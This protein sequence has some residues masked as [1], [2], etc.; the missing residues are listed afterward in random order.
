M[1]SLDL[2]RRLQAAG[3]VWTPASG[4]RFVVPDRDMDEEVFVVSNM[5]VDVHELPTGT[6]L[7][8][9]GTTEWALDSIL[10]REVVWLPR[11]DQ[12]RDLLG[13]SFR[14]LASTPGGFSVTVTDHVGVEERHGDIDA[15]CAYARAALA[16]LRWRTV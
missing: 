10:E 16:V 4:D 6:L 9:N 7:G 13:Q 12:L 1:I 15:E 3:L 5:V 2:A 14:G 11:E 8:F